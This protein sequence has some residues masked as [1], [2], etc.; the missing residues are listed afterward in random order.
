MSTF[1]LKPE[2]TRF[3]TQ[4]KTLDETHKMIVTEFQNRKTNLP[5]KKKK[6]ENF[7]NQ[8]S[9]LESQDP[10]S[11]SNEDIQ[12][13]SK[14][15]SDIKYLKNEIYDIENSISELEYYS[16]TNDLLMDYY[17]ILE[18]ENE[19]LY[20]AFPELSK[21]KKDEKIS[22]TFDKLDLLN[23]INKEDKKY[24]KIS[25]RRKKKDNINKNNSILNYFNQ[26]QVSNETTEDCDPEDSCT[27]S[28]KVSNSCSDRS[29]N[30]R[31]ELLDQYMMLIDNQYVC[32]K[33]RNINIIKICND[34]GNDK[35]LV[36][37]EGIFV[38]Q[39]CGEVEMIIIE[40]ERPS[41]KDSSAP[42]K[43]GYPYRTNVVKSVLL[44]ILSS[45]W[46]NN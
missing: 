5:K 29:K 3:L 30:D 31:A 38:C 10:S 13:K 4:I 17:E 2:K 42:E 1:K 19:S 24:K 41:Y 6:L 39:N 37:S 44:Y 7:I 27:E 40:S 43:P 28:S 25:K 46:E 8:L 9:N 23:K 20:E 45:I 15:K 11:Y 36:Q 35:T 14:L 18:Q 33:R 22:E 26:Q 12:L 34:C 32:E 16:K 21:A